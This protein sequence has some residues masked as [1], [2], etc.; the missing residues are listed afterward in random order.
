MNNILNE[1]K[2]ARKY[3]IETDDNIEG[4]VKI[5]VE[6]VAKVEAMIKK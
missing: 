1:L 5:K 6:N 3:M 2:E 4:I